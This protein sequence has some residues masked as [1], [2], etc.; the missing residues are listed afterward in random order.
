[1]PKAKEA[2]L[3]AVE[4]DDTLADGHVQMGTVHF[5]YDYDWP[6]AERELRRAVELNPNYAPAQEFLGWFL[7]SMGR[8]EEGL[9]HVRR[10]VALDPLSVENQSNLGWQLYF[11]RRYDDALA[12]S[13]KAIDLEP[14]Y[15]G[16]YYYMGQAYA[17]QRHFAE[18]IAE[19][20][21]GRELDPDNPLP[22][23]E[24]A[25]DYALAGR[26]AEARRALADLLAAAKR[27]YVSK[28]GFVVIYAA[29]GD[30]DQAL[31]QLEQTYRDRSLFMAMLKVEP[32]MDTLRSDP[33]FQDLMRRLNFP[34]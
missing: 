4:L 32:E 12:E 2:A 1:M 24:L 7:V 33:R 31:A 22:Q 5:L 30:K 23:V 3:K 16:S 15:W 26:T 20:T 13:R 28:A 6:A 34:Q 29:L 19:E 9:E 11:A 25:R 27:Q 17:Q 10:S 14:A 21:K 18:A 8:T